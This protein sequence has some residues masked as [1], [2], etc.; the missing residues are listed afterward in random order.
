MTHPTSWQN[1][2]RQFSENFLGTDY[3]RYAVKPN[4][5][6]SFIKQKLTEQREQ[7]ATE[8]EKIEDKDITYETSR[9]IDQV[10]SIIKENK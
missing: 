7:I 5:I 9:I 3:W 1:I 6:L 10:L 4:E 8:V 2:E